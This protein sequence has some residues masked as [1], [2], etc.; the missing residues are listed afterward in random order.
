MEMPVDIIKKHTDIRSG[1][2]GPDG[3]TDGQRALNIDLEL[4]RKFL[5]FPIEEL[6]AEGAAIEDD[7]GV[8]HAGTGPEHCQARPGEN[9]N[10]LLNHARNALT[11]YWHLKKLEEAEAE[12]AAEQAKINQR[13]KPGVYDLWTGGEQHVAVVTADRRILF[14]T[15]KTGTKDFT[16]VF[17]GMENKSRW[18]FTLIETG[19]ATAE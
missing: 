1:L 8:L 4:Q 2:V 14:L 18:K 3:L 17:D 5:F 11:L 13:P 15:S 7:R 19:L 9:P 10:W 12:Q 16:E 6:E